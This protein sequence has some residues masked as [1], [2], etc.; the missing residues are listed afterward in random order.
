MWIGNR[1]FHSTLISQ[2]M[3][4]L[5]SWINPPALKTF[6]QLPWTT[7]AITLQ[8]SEQQLWEVLLLFCFLVLF[9]AEQQFHSSITM[10]FHRYRGSLWPNLQTSPH[11]EVMWHKCHWSNPEGTFWSRLDLHTVLVL[12]L[13]KLSFSL[14]SLATHTTVLLPPAEH[15]GE[16]LCSL[17]Y[18]KCSG[19]Q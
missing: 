2:G 4:K 3:Y 1:V 17:L 15:Q 13:L 7:G 14:L 10:K 8:C 16:G 9:K 6:V 5:P 19:C 12:L 18:T 11:S